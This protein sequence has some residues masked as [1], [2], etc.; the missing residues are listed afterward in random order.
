MGLDKITQKYNL[1]L[2]RA[3]TLEG[4]KFHNKQFGGGIVFTSYNLGDLCA[5]INSLM[6]KE[7]TK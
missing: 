5:G 6:E 1:A 2:S 7:A 4:R 3:K